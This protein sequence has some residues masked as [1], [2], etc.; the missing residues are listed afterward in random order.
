MTV[1][2]EA[3][4]ALKVARTSAPHDVVIVDTIEMRHPSFPNHIYLTNQKEDY[5]ATLEPDAGVSPLMVL[6]KSAGFKITLPRQ[7]VSGVQTLNLALSNLD[8]EVSRHLEL[9]MQNPE[10]IEVFYR[11]YIHSKPESPAEVPP[12]KLSLDSAVVDA[13]VANGKATT[14]DWLNKKLHK[15]IYDV[16][17]F[18]GIA[19]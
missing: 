14:V 8:R 17:Q 6:F 13:F 11:P 15:L 9:A 12:R 16:E 3:A 5:A 7:G 1:A 19:R 18:P 10:P 2:E 4:E